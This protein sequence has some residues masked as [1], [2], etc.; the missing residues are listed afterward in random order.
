MS[1]SPTSERVIGIDPGSIRC[2]VGIVERDRGRLVHIWSETIE[3]GRGDFPERLE[4]I[5]GRIHHLCELYQP[6]RAGIE[7]IFHYR[8]ADSALKL[9]HARGVAMLALRHANLDIQEY[10]PGEVKKTVGS[11]GAAA[12]EQVRAMVMRLLSLD[13]A[14]GLDASDALAIAITA[15]WRRE[16]TTASAARRSPL[17]EAIARHAKP[18]TSSGFQQRVNEAIARAD[19]RRTR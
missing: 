18:Q 6:T 8:N 7:G 2:G 10:Q 12:K 4:T 1:T 9:G 5:Y 14:P 13:E 17:Q 16:L 19:A 15:A 11:Y 3:C